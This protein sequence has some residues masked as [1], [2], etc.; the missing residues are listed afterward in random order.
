[1]YV[2]PAFVHSGAWNRC[3]QSNGEDGGGDNV[4]WTTFYARLHKYH[5]MTQIPDF[6][7]LTVCI[8]PIPGFSPG[9]WRI[10]FSFVR[11]FGWS[12]SEHLLPTTKSR[13]LEPQGTGALVP[14]LRPSCL[15]CH[16]KEGQV[17][18][19]QTFFHILGFKP[20]KFFSWH[21]NHLLSLKP[22]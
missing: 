11:E 7:G 1:M 3:S 9:L 21:P 15:W 22:E 4:G 17:E 16:L 13:A 6:N 19:V 10:I 20:S 14:P 5:T 2:K 8:P 18:D 12:V